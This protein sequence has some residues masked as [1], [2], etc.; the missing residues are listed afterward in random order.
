MGRNRLVT[1]LVA[2]AVQWTV[3]LA[4]AQPVPSEQAVQR[5]QATLATIPH[6]NEADF[7]SE[8]SGP[9]YAAARNFIVERQCASRSANPLL[10]VAHPTGVSLRTGQE[11]GAFEFP[12]RVAVLSDVPNLY[13]G[14]M[15]ALVESRGLPAEV[16]AKLK[17]EIPEA[18]KKLVSR[19][20]RMIDEYDP[21]RCERPGQIPRRLGPPYVFVVPTH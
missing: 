4:Q 18:Y 6:L 2:A 7:L 5:L 15:S 13:L 19:T 3:D 11:A 12:L 14:N 20:L 10:A 8:E 21:A 9:R 17:Q 1:L 16:T